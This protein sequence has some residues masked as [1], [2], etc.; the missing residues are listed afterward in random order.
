M[1]ESWGSKFEVGLRAAAFGAGTVLTALAFLGCHLWRRW[2]AK[3]KA[4]AGY[5]VEFVGTLGSKERH[6]SLSRKLGVPDSSLTIGSEGENSSSVSPR[7]K[8][9]K[10]LE[11]GSA[12]D[13]A[14]HVAIEAEPECP[15]AP[16]APRPKSAAKHNK[17][18]SFSESRGQ[19]GTD[20]VPFCFRTHSAQSTEPPAAKQK[21]SSQESKGRGET[22]TP[23]EIDPS[24]PFC[25]KT[26]ST[27]STR[28]TRSTE[29]PGAAISKTL[30]ARSSH[31]MVEAPAPIA[32]SRDS[33]AFWSG[34]HEVAPTISSRVSAAEQPWC[35]TSP[36]PAHLVHGREGLVRC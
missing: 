22:R 29:A 21:S 34:Q 13:N 35:S 6:I 15:M 19:S 4:Q 10:S 12:V 26:H 30:S 25:S 33:G 11:S 36:E 32:A 24:T 14:F 5:G 7:S 1:T 23:P 27:H 2:R 17:P 31:S 20:S 16:W 8:K 18:S 9:Q 3:A 28:S